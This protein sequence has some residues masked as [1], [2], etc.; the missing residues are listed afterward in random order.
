MGIVRAETT[1]MKLEEVAMLR[2]QDSF[3]FSIHMILV[4]CSL[5]M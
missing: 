2:E 1:K 5:N 4:H 3:P